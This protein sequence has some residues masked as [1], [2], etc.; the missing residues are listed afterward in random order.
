MW[1]TR[2]VEDDN[3]AQFKREAKA[4]AS[5]ASASRQEFDR[6]LVIDFEANGHNR[7]STSWEIVEFPCVVVDTATKQVVAEFHRYVRPTVRPD[8]S[9]FCVEQCGISQAT[10]DAAD[11]ID[12]VL[13]DFIQ[14][15]DSLRYAAGSFAVVTCGD[16]D[17]KTALRAEVRNKGLPRLPAY[18]KQWV[19]IKKV[20]AGKAG[21]S[22]PKGMA[23]MLADLQ[24]PLIG[25]HHS[26]ID[27]AR[28]IAAILVRLLHEDVR[29]GITASYDG[30]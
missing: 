15:V 14:W 17:M 2:S 23:G 25:R 19:N 7:D 10:T 4:A 29:V 24:M 8:L 27:D 21:Y 3:I 22:R 11:P 20:F 26:G 12:V 28:N 5:A 18:L 6:Y 9:E 1:G 16:Y 30:S 13:R